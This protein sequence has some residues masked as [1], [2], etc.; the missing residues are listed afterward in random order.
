VADSG[1]INIAAI[2]NGLA[3]PYKHP[4]EWRAYPFY[5]IW[6]PL[7]QAPFSENISQLVLDKLKN[8]QFTQS[9]IDDLRAL[10]SADK[11]FDQDI[12]DKQI[13]V[14]RG[15]ILNLTNAIEQHKSPWQLVHMP[16]VTIERV[17]IGRARRFIQ[18]VRSQ[19]P[20][21]QWC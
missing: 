8:S 4:D 21:F 10:F 18:H 11:G 1:S 5:W 6:H 17:K 14:M 13:A 15:Q 2:D 9:L 7:A 16:P 3:F 19:P 12:F 20:F